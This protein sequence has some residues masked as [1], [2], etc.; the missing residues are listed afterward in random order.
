M[1]GIFRN[2]PEEHQ[3]TVQYDIKQNSF[4]LKKILKVRE[5]K[6]NGIRDVWHEF[7]NSA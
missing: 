7:R 2:N 4:V 3:L 5:K 6:S 1:E